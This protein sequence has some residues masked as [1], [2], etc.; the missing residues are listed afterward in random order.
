MTVDSASQRRGYEQLAANRDQGGVLGAGV[1]ALFSPAISAQAQGAGPDFYWWTPLLV[2][3]EYSGWPQE[4]VAHTRTCYI[5]DF[6]SIGKLLISG[7]DALKFLSSVGVNN[8]SRLE[9]GRIAHFIQVDNDGHIASEGVLLRLQ[10]EEFFY[11]GSATDWTAWQLS[12]GSWDAECRDVSAE[13]FIFEVQGP[14]S[15]EVLEK[16][17]GPELREL[18]FNHYQRMTVDGIDLGVLR[19]GISGELG[20]ELHGPAEVAARVWESVVEAGSDLGIQRLGMGSLMVAHI[21]AGIATAGIDYLPA[22]IITPGA[23]RTSPRGEA[24]GSFIPMNGIGD[25]FRYPAELGWGGRVSLDTHDFIGRDALRRLAEEGGS[26]RRLVGLVW[27]ADDV[28]AV[29]S[30]IYDETPAA[31]MRLPRFV[32]LATD[33]VVVNG[34]DVGLSTSRTF[35]AHLVQT[36]SLGVLDDSIALGSDVEVVWGAPGTPQRMIRAVV[37]AAPLK[38]DNRRV[39]VAAL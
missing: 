26:G 37:Q 27:N 39:D 29:L 28:K 11:S 30:S 5:G 12:Q 20:Y 1:P 16:L 32:G 22:S 18:K 14:K 25:F 35:S 9:I 17:F 33:R 7:P 4:S 24:A 2:P 21:E 3:N 31:P 19:T 36:I 6:T 34:Q 23:Q 8:L 10:E 15:V 13:Q 38:P